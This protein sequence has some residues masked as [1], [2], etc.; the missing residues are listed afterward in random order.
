MGHAASRPHRLGPAAD[1]RR[2]ACQ[3]A[4]TGTPADDT[5]VVLSALR[6]PASN[7]AAEQLAGQWLAAVNG[8][9]ESSFASAAAANPRQAVLALALAGCELRMTGTPAAADRPYLGWLI[10]HAAYEATATELRLLEDDP[11]FTA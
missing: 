7:D 1:A 4:L 11:A 3:A 8:D 6:N 10:E 9:A 2:A 5:V